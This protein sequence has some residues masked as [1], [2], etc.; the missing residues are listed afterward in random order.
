[1]PRFSVG[2]GRRKSAA[3]EDVFQN[4]EVASNEPSS[5]RV[6]ERTDVAAGKSFDGGV[7]MGM[8]RAT[9][10]M[11]YQKPNLSQSSV[12][13]NMFADLKPSNRYVAGFLFLSPPVPAASF[14]S[15]SRDV[16]PPWP[17]LTTPNKP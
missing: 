10:S 16:C 17:D 15:L 4:V 12:E 14:H 8:G 3:A 6:L 9:T 13:D 5:F 1:M 11:V 2:F 7:R